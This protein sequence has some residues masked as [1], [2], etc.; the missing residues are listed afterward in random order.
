LLADPAFVTPGRFHKGNI[1]THSTRSDGA[2]APEEVCAAYREAG[3]DFLALTDHFLAKYDFPVVDTRN[4]R[5][6]SFTTILGAEVHAPAT[7]LGELWHLLAVGLPVDFAPTAVEETAPMLARRCLAAGAFL[8]I[9][10]PGWYA[11]T[12]ADADSI[13]GAHAVEIYNHTSQ[14]RT[15][16]GDGSGLID[17]LHAAGRRIGICAVDD[18][19]FHCADCFGGFV[20]VKS[21]VNEPEALLSSL[22]A[23]AY[24]S[25][26]GPRIEN[27]SYGSDDVEIACSPASAVI[28]LGRGS[29]AVQHVAQGTTRVTLPL[30]PLR[31]GGFARVVVVD[32]QGRRAWTNPVWW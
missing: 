18:A 14:V 3:Y 26:Q 4:L 29:K 7:S 20:I 13:A 16:R 10:H 31:S 28:V 27:V 25:S 8:V 11:L 21:A 23:G 32:A 5:T 1:H 6:P 9:A 17:Q 19:H 24:Y 15:D 22:K 2:L 12:T 30:A